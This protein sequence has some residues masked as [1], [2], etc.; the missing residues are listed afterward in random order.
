[1][2]SFR[3]THVPICIIGGGSGA[4]NLVAQLMREEGVLGKD[5]RVF[6]PSNT[7]HY[8]PAY[9]MVGGGLIDVDRHSS[10]VHRPA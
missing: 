6:E 8:G 10:L 2:F 5:I 9:T 7:H 4:V 3:Q 1:M